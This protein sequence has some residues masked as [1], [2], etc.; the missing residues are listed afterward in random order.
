[1][2]PSTPSSLNIM[3]ISDLRDSFQSIGSSN[4]CDHK[5]LR[6]SYLH[7]ICTRACKLNAWWFRFGNLCATYWRSD[8]SPVDYHAQEA[9]TDYHRWWKGNKQ[10]LLV[11]SNP[12]QLYELQ[13]HEQA[14]KLISCYCLQNANKETFLQRFCD[15]V[16]VFLLQPKEFQFHE[17]KSRFNINT[18]L[19]FNSYFFFF[20]F[21]FK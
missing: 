5:C 16:K 9:D 15:I 10:F 11:H 17:E 8:A 1:M 20:F 21:F 14:G 19:Q 3:P 4:N 6:L 18:L 13:I 2:H 7:P 12:N